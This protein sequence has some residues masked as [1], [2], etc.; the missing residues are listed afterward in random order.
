VLRVCGRSQVE[1][2]SDFVSR[3]HGNHVYVEQCFNVH[4]NLQFWGFYPSILVNE[5]MGQKSMDP[6]TLN[7]LSG[8]PDKGVEFQR[9]RLV[10]QTSRPFKRTAKLWISNNLVEKPN[11]VE[12]A[13]G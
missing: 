12:I 3:F 2:E 10:C 13:F 8:Y 11:E 7:F 9:W 4:L 5:K 1:H 6:M